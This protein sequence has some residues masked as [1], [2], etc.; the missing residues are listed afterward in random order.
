MADAERTSLPPDV[1][2]PAPSTSA[3]AAELDS[4]SKGGKKEKPRK[5]YKQLVL[6]SPEQIAQEDLMNNCGVRTV[7][8]GVMGAGLGAVF[9]VFMVTMDAAVRPSL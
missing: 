3:P 8:S 7:L 5:V 1:D 4:G 2:A 6:P 9:G